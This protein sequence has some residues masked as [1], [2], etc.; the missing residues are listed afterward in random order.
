MMEF[1]KEFA[2]W[3]QALSFL[4]NNEGFFRKLKNN[5]IVYIKPPGATRLYVGFDDLSRLGGKSPQRD[6]WGIKF[7]LQQGWA[8]LGVMPDSS[9]WYRDDELF[10]ALEGLSADG[11]FDGY[12]KILFS[13]TSMGAY[14]SLAFADIAPGANVLAFAPQN[15]LDPKKVPWER[16]FERGRAADWSGRYRE[17]A[18]GIARANQVYVLYD[19]LERGDKLHANMVQGDNVEKRIAYGCGHR[20][21]LIA[22]NIGALKGLTIHAME[23]ELTPENYRELM[24][25]RG[26]TTVYRQNI[27]KRLK[28]KR[29]HKRARAFADVC[30][31]MKKDFAQL[32]AEAK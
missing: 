25:W 20:I 6:P 15:T 18:D 22:R 32:N 21:A 17:G 1:N 11:L 3:Q 8:Y 27:V 10:D 16:R 30:F 24:A 4:S 7:A 5:S 14:A 13:G 31:K 28:A 12:E 26:A 19:P 9:Y 23:G 29:R 2:V